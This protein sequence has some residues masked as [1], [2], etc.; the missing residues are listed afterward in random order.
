MKIRL[1]GAKEFPADRRT[2]EQRDMKK[3]IVAF[4]NFAKKGQP[5]PYKLFV[6]EIL[7]NL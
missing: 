4:R 3:L 6:V 5:L 2:D 7:P 1:L